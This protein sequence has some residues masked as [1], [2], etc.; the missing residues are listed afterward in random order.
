MQGQ[1]PIRLA[2][3]RVHLFSTGCL[4][5]VQRSRGPPNYSPSDLS[6]I[7]RTRTNIA[8]LSIENPELVQVDREPVAVRSFS[9]VPFGNQS[10]R[11]RG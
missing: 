7:A 5:E 10:R 2:P 1:L 3:Y 8:F 9:S 11:P 4:C 6:R